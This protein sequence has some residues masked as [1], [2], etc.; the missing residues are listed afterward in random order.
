MRGSFA[1]GILA[2]CL[3]HKNLLKLIFLVHKIL[4]SLQERQRRNVLM[5]QNM[6][7]K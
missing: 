5:I 7:E 3:V 1:Q 2:H 4:T 6:K